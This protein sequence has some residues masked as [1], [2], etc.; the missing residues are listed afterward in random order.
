MEVIDVLILIALFA[1][2]VSDTSQV[3]YNQSA[4]RLM[5]EH[6]KEIDLL[7]DEIAG[8]R[9]DKILTPRPTASEG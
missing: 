3:V 7:A 8:L 4:T 5:I 1:C 2:L 9:G 6:G